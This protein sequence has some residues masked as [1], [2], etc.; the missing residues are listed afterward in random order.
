MSRV[1]AEML[2]L[3]ALTLAVVLILL[4]LGI[5]Q[6]RAER[7][8]QTQ[9]RE[10]ARTTASTQDWMMTLPDHAINKGPLKTK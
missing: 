6:T 9:M 4:I 7:E 1:E 8:T 5:R 2:A 10:V 3:M